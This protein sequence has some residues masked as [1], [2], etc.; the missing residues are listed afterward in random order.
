MR[1]RHYA[2]MLAAALTLA[3]ATPAY[4]FEPVSNGTP[5]GQPTATQHQPNTPA[6]WTIALAAAGGL[7]ITGTGLA[8]RRSRQRRHQTTARA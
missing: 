5:G 2:P 7:T 4:A 1:P 8:T 3:S 6:D